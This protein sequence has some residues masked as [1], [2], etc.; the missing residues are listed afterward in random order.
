MT[1]PASPLRILPT[2]GRYDYSPIV[3]R[4]TYQWPN[5]ARLAFYVALNIEAFPFGEGMG[6]EL[7]P[8]QPEPDVV[9]HT[10]RDWGNRVGIWRL[11]ELLDEFD[12]PASALLNTAIYDSCPQIAQALRRRGDEIV[13]HGHTNAERQ[14]EMDAEAEARM[15]ENVTARLRAE[16]GKAPK[17]WMGPWVNETVRTPDLLARNGYAYVMDWMMDD[18]PVMLRTAHGPLV[19]LPYAR[20]TNDITALHGAKWTPQEWADMLIDQVD[21]MLRQ[22]RRQ[23]LVFNVSLHPYLM[24]A[25][26]LKHLRRFFEYLATVR[27]ELWVARC[28]D[29]ALFAKAE[30]EGLG[31]R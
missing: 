24:H 19:A 1:E 8:R 11:V 30:M 12:L 13:G 20:P 5:G 29:I 6:P 14:A 9:N 2:H 4:P 10:W 16:E 21:E 17:G 25:F 15:I 3:D 22:S 18:Q 28:A 7:N 26:R 23:P 27:N 31:G